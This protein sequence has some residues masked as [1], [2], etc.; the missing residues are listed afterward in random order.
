MEEIEQRINI[1]R[2]TNSGYETIILPQAP[3]PEIRLKNLRYG[4]FYLICLLLVIPGFVIIDLFFINGFAWKIHFFSLVF[5][6]IGIYYLVYQLN[7]YKQ[8]PIPEKLILMPESISY[9]SGVPVLLFGFPLSNRFEFG[10]RFYHKRISVE[11]SRSDI[12]TLKL[13][14]QWNKPRLFITQNHKRREIGLDLTKSE[15]EWLLNY[16]KSNYENNLT[17]ALLRLRSG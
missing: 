1:E 12:L 11:Y 9:D 5:C 7:R 3:N 4:I 6:G 15:R 16:I 10:N 17:P 14:T 2:D 13:R 8:D